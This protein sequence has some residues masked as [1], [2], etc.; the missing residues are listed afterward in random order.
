M[1]R[2]IYIEQYGAWWLATPAQ[3]A[4][5][6]ALGAVGAEWDYDA[7]ATRLTRRPTSC[8]YV[9]GGGWHCY[10]EGGVIVRPLDWPIEDWQAEQKG[11]R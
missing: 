6:V 1:H 9:E 11:V 5:I 2:Y 8:V 7:M 4:A 3:W 10:R